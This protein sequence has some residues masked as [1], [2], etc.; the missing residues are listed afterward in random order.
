LRELAES[1]KASGAESIA[2]CL[3][4]SFADPANEIAV[5][6]AL[7]G[8]GLPISLSHVILPEFREYE[9][10]STVA[11]NAYLSPKVGSYLRELDSSLQRFSSCAGF[12]VM[13]SS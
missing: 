4:F 8:L 9:R 6:Q 12:E 2:I 3:L 5:D 7:R 13:Q 1:I 10:A 11:V